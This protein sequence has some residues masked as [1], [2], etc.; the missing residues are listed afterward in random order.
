MNEPTVAW[1]ILT[2]LTLLW[3]AVLL[4]VGAGLLLGIKK[5]LKVP[6]PSYRKALALLTVTGITSVIAGTVVDAI[7]IGS[8][9]NLAVTLLAFLAFHWLL[10][11]YYRVGWQKSLQI[12]LIFTVAATILELSVI[13]PTRRFIVE[14]YYVRGDSMMPAYQDHDF[15]LINKFSRQFIRGDVIILRHPSEPKQFLLRRI[16]G[17]P[18]E[19]IE[20]VSGGVTVNGQRLPES[21]ALGQQSEPTTFTL[22]ESEFFV[23]ADNRDATLDSRTFGPVTAKGILGKVFYR[24]PQVGVLGP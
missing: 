8:P 17:L 13:I 2:V 10:K 4:V 15:L 16:V 14:P 24:F 9:A 20:I 22:Q 6:N 5:L 18:S 3:F 19:H 11:K 1:D 21:H 7:R 23:L 12:Y